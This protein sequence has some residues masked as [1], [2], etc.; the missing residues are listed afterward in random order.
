LLLNLLLVMIKSILCS[1][2]FFRKVC[3]A[4]LYMFQNDL[5][6]KDVEQ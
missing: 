2:C 5:F 1:V 4:S 6:V 3:T